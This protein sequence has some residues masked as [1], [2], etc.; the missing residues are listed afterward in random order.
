[1]AALTPGNE[2]IYLHEY[3]EYHINVITQKQ[4]K[5]QHAIGINL[6]YLKDVRPKCDKFVLD[7][8]TSKKKPN[9]RTDSKS[10]ER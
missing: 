4:T 10:Q 7:S 1:M 9:S 2:V 3:K 6:E 8:L 5:T